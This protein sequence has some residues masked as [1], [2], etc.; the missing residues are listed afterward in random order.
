MITVAVRAPAIAH[1]GLQ[2]SCR[3][4]LVDVAD[5]RSVDLAP[6]RE[7]RWEVITLSLS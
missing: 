4:G 7:A 5:L 3:L 1:S 6:T 2:T